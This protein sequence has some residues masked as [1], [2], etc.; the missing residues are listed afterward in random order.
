MYSNSDDTNQGVNSN[1]NNLD[2]NSYTNNDDNGY[3]NVEDNSDND[4]NA[5]DDNMETSNDDGDNNDDN[6]YTNNDYNN[7]E[8]VEDNSDYDINVNND[9]METSN[10]DGD[11]NDDNNSDDGKGS[12]CNTDETLYDP[13]VLSCM[14]INVGGLT[15]K[16]DFPSFIEF[17]G[18]Y[19]VIVITESKFSDTD[20]INIEYKQ[21]KVQTK[22]CGILVLI[23]NSNLP[24]LK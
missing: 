19:D 16:L 14:A 5:N 11:N 17:V 6:S 24:Y 10:D 20:S 15:A 22:I 21:M 12:D 8:H 4:I 18:S 3:E 23:R 7:Y 2:L 1:Q 9:N 13:T